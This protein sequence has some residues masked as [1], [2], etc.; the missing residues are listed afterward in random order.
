MLRYSVLRNVVRLADGASLVQP[1]LYRRFSQ[2]LY[3]STASVFNP[4]ANRLQ[5]PTVLKADKQIVCG[6]C[7]ES[8][9]PTKKKK[10][11]K[12]PPAVEHVG[13]LDL[14]IG[15]IVEVNKAPDADTLY[16]TKVDIG[17]EYLSIVAGLVKYF[18]VDELLGKNA[19]ILCNLKASKLRGYLSEG[20]IM[21]AKSGE[22]ME[23]LQ[24]P[25]SAQPGDL[26]YCESYDRVP[27]TERDKKKLY[28]SLASDMLTDDNAIACYKGSLF[29]LPEKGNI[30][31][32][33]LKNAPIS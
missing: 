12:N 5:Q 27:A 26:V 32:K 16:L 22:Q 9:G 33:S 29:Y 23:L 20:M 21:C 11:K 13:R 3:T 25:E 19:V 17:G 1:K 15:K 14:R 4:S 24:P 7:T 18:A 2:Q 10:P 6:F 28:D 31:T 8:T 30:A